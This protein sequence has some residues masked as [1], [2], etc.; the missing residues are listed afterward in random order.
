MP[1]YYEVFGE[2]RGVLM[3]KR[4]TKYWEDVEMFLARPDDLVIATYPKSGKCLCSDRMLL[5]HLGSMIISVR[6]F[7]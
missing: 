4:F 5:R 3:D 2:F 7:T 6:V 1:E